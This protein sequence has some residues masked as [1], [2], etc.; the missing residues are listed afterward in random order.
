MG[1][2]GSLPPVSGQ[3]S[4]TESSATAKQDL[5]A[6]LLLRDASG[7]VSMLKYVRSDNATIKQH[8]CVKQS[9]ATSKTD[10]VVVTATADGGNPGKFL[11][12]AA[13]TIASNQYGW[14]YC[15]GYV[16]AV[17]FSS[18]VASES[19]VMLSGSLAGA[20]VVPSPTFNATS[21]AHEATTVYCVGVSRGA[22]SNSA[23]AGSLH[24][25]GL[26]L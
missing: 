23:H 8:L 1:F 22:A 18:T 19:M 9:V 17:N 21:V 6:V 14:V 11:G 10:Y 25:F 24:L 7:F 20:L 5:G 26:Y 4:V 16:P 15:G 12:V 13:G 3:A 2:L